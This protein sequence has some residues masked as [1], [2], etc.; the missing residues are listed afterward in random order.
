ME[1]GGWRVEDAGCEEAKDEVERREREVVKSR[2]LF[3]CDCAPFETRSFARLYRS[4]CI[5]IHHA[6]GTSRTS[7]AWNQA[8]VHRATQTWPVHPVHSGQQAAMLQQHRH[9]N[10]QQQLNLIQYLPHH[11]TRDHPSRSK[12]SPTDTYTRPITT[13]LVPVDTSKNSS[14]MQTLLL[15]EA[16][17]GITKLAPLG[18]LN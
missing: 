5:L 9:Q 14:K 13:P 3:L 17:P 2:G 15:L 6:T 10:L 1:G 18:S 7:K 4:L 12:E 11:R 8:R 16:L